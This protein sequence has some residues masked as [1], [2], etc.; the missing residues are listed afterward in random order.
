MKK[1]KYFIFIIMALFMV[2]SPVFAENGCD[3]LKIDIDTKI[4]SSVHWIIVILQIAIPVVL[5]IFGSID[6]LK[7]VT[8]SK[9]DEIKK[10]QQTF[11]KRLIA[12]ALVFFITAIVR[13]VVSFATGNDKS[14]LNCANCFLNGPDDCEVKQKTDSTD[15]TKTDVN[16]KVS[17]QDDE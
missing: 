16:V 4:T 15:K 10:G 3:Y 1:L 13:L 5:V 12:A 8:A 14:I 17:N 9:E 11:I 6:F 7:A 2:T